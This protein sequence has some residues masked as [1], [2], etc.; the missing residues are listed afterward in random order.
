MAQRSGFFNALKQGAIW[1]RQ[2]NADDYSTQMEALVGSGVRRSG[3]NDLRVNAAGGMN[4]SINVGFAFVRG[5]WFYNDSTFTEFSI[6]TAPVG[7]RSRIDRV[8]IRLDRNTQ[9]RSVQFRYLQGV[10][11][12]SPVAPA[13]TRDDMIYEIA[14]AEIRVRSSV[15]SI[16]Q[17]DI[18]DLRANDDLCGWLTIPLGDNQEWFA[19]F[20][21]DFNEWFT[22]VKNTLASVTLFKEYNWHTTTTEQTTVVTFNIP[23]Y[24]SS[25]VDIVQV[26]VNGIREIENTDYTLNGSIITFTNSKIVGTDI[27]VFVYKSIDGTGLG[28][29][30]DEITEL[31]NEMATIKNIGEYIYICNGF[32]DNV[33]LSDLAQ[34]F[35]STDTD[36]NQMIIKVYGKFGANAPYAGSGTSVSRYRWFSLGGAGSTK[37]KIVFDFEGCSEITLNCKGGLH[38]IGFYG[39]GINVKNANITVNCDYSDSSF[40]MFSASNGYIYVENCRFWVN[41]YTNSFIS[42]TGTFNNCKISVINRGGH[43][44]CFNVSNNGLLRINGGEFYSYTGSSSYNASVIFMDTVATSGVAV[45]NGMNCPTV[46]VASRYQKNAIL[47]NAGYGAFNDTITALTVKS[48]SNQNVRG[49]YPVSKPDRM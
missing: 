11:A 43:S 12:E 48:S 1:D 49:T 22:E 2:Y 13:L 29:V 8:V 45:S 42:E 47:C 36:N 40:Q 41:A 16:T 35:L 3:E 14:L 32:D 9:T 38:Y 24:D 33:K 4:L 28:S 46:A 31:Q 25:G 6:P 34:E 7:S 39:L 15:T 30:S 10:D 19:N 20:D 17:D 21:T 27:D 23:Q 5:R 37:R 18:T 44:Y 26:Y